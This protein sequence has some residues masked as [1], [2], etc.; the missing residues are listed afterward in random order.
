MALEDSLAIRQ[1]K[2][3]HLW[4][5]IL[6]WILVF[7]LAGWAISHVPLIDT[8]EV[9][10]RLTVFQITL[11]LGVNCFLILAFSARWWMVLN[12]M[13][14]RVPYL[15]LSLHRLA[16]FSISYFT[17]GP[18]VGGE[19]LQAMMLKN[20]HQIP[21]VTAST[22]IGIDRLIE[23][24]INLSIMMAGAVVALQSRFLS[25]QTGET[26]VLLLG[27]L[28]LLPVAYIVL[29]MSGQQPLSWLLTRVFG[30]FHEQTF[31]KR[32]LDGTKQSEQQAIHIFQK[33]ALSVSVV[34]II[35][36]LS[37]LVIIAEYWMVL[38]FIG[39]IISPVQ[40]II[41][42]LVTRVAFLAPLPSGLGA[43]EASQVLA[44]E[45][46]GLEP[47][48]GLTASLL[49]RVRDVIF[50]LIGLWWAGSKWINDERKINDEE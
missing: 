40:L 8:W 3:Q 41:L 24:A 11:L 10:Q 28:T 22:S 46:L 29:L 4:I 6:L 21:M 15:K 30:Q 43:L 38:R 5:H 42:L 34:V 7:G 31:I 49:I 48:A 20:H 9:L 18:Q 37:W 45:A 27:I 14:Y 35:S 19:P 16:G 33:K 47:A 2:R 12:T 25:T 44:F 26:S 13:G 17:P 50:G 39:V 32:A 23:I 36:L 1:N